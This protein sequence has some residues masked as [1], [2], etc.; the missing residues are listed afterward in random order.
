MKPNRMLV[1][2]TARLVLVWARPGRRVDPQLDSWLIAFLRC[3]RDCENV[4]KNGIVGARGGGGG[5]AVA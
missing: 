3:T 5:G 2:R 1:T 4:R